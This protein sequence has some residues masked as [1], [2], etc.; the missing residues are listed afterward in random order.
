MWRY[1]LY[2]EAMERDSWWALVNVAVW[3]V[4]SGYVEGQLM[5]TGECGGTGFIKW[6]C[7]GTAGGHW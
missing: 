6:L 4:S 5:G 3:A 2:R 1:G 7:G